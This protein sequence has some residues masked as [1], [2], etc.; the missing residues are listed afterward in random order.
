MN[1]IDPLISALT[2]CTSDTQRKVRLKPGPQLWG[3]GDEEKRDAQV[4]KEILFIEAWLD[5]R[6]AGDIDGAAADCASDISIRLPGAELAG[7]DEVKA[8]VF[9]KAAPKPLI[10]LQPV[11][12]MPGQ[13]HVYWRLAVFEFAGTKQTRVRREWHLV[14]DDTGRMKIS[15]IVLTRVDTDGGIP[16]L[17]L[18][19]RARPSYVPQELGS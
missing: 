17:L 6:E 12:E 16:E 18:G 14:Y 11:Q 5:K 3:F 13:R 10:V 19:S 15:K 4:R 2:C 7:L 8:K 9:V 1:P